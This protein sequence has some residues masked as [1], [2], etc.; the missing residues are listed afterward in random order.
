MSNS[1]MIDFLVKMYENSTEAIFFLDQEGKILALNPTA[2]EI[3]DDRLLES[4]QQGNPSMLCTF[5]RG[6]TND[7]NE[8]TCFDCHI[9]NAEDDFSSFQVYLETKNK[10]TVPYAASYHPI[11]EEK[12]TYV[13]ML[14][15]LT[16]QFKTQEDLYK[17]KLMKQTIEAQENERK[18][19]SRELHDSVVQELISMLVDLRLTK[20]MDDPA[21]VQ[22][23]T[24][25]MEGTLNRLVEDVRNLSVVLRPASLD[26]LGLEA[27]FRSHFKWVEKNYGLDVN[28]SST[29]NNRRYRQDIETAVYRIGQEAILNAIKYAETFQV[30]VL[31]TELEGYIEMYVRDEGIGFNKEKPDVKGS[32]IGLSGMEERAELVGGTI[33]IDT[34]VG[35]GTTVYLSIP[36]KRSQS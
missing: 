14:R 9:Q 13:F 30:S 1:Q 8:M 15:D 19:I 23:Q 7:Q 6:Y 3:V 32:G 21:E 16:T 34:E 28:F 5:C 24:Q 25:Q 18:R 17:N 31:L 35:K 33:S 10:G 20:Y 4:L 26:D 11:D 27:A 36:V 29:L 12:S 2:R 22:K